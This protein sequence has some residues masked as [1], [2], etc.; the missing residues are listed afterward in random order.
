MTLKLRHDFNSFAVH[1]CTT[2]TPST[3]THVAN[4]IRLTAQLSWWQRLPWCWQSNH[5]WEQY[6]YECRKSHRGS[7]TGSLTNG[8]GLRRVNSGGQASPGGRRRS[9]DKESGKSKSHWIDSAKGSSTPATKRI[10]RLLG[11]GIGV[12]ASILVFI[13]V[14]IY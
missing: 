7:P 6:Q 9:K 4:C 2:C 13:C 12:G 3:I 11:V 5:E 8:N 1:A 14:F 10:W